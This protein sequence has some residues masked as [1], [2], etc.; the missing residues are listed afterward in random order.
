MLS[1]FYVQEIL[2]IIIYGTLVVLFISVNALFLVWMERRL[3]ARFQL[4]RG[5]IHVG[6]QGALQ[7]IADALKL[8]SKELVVPSSA[9]KFCYLLAPVLV[10]APLICA[11]LILPF[12]EHVIIRDL[13]IGF[14]LFLR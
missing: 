7:T 2:K 14:L 13:N 11:F 12:G 6:W 1:N 8:L 10:F 5:P 3:A 9:D 4:R